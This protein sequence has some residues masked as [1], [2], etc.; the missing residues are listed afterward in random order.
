MVPPLSVTSAW[1]G[2]R[3]ITMSG[4]RL[5]NSREF[6]RDVQA[7]AQAQA[8]DPVLAGVAGGGDHALDAPLAEA[9]R[10]HDGVETAQALGPEQTRHQLGVDPVELDT[11]P[12]VV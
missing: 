10:D 9:T 8:R 4:E 12:V 2:I 3:S 5:S 11:R 1:S 6:G 7:E